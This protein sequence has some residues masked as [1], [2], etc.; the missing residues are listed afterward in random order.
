MGSPV[1]CKLYINRSRAFKFICR[2]FETGV[3]ACLTELEIILLGIEALTIRINILI[4]SVCILSH[5]CRITWNTAFHMC[6]MCVHVRSLAGSIVVSYRVI[7]AICISPWSYPCKV[8][9]EVNS[10]LISSLSKSV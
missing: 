2:E 1:E 6:S 8:I 4:A 3:N 5:E 9:L 10:G 7:C